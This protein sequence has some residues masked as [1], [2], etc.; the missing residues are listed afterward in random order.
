MREEVQAVT[1][2][3]VAGAMGECL[4]TPLTKTPVRTAL[5]HE[6]VV[7]VQGEDVVTEAPGARCLRTSA[8][9]RDGPGGLQQ[10]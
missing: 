2:G 3:V 7:E 9:R 5:L 4:W 10:G 1:A 6:T 8:L